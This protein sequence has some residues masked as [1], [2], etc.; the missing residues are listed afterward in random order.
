MKYK[1]IEEEIKELSE[2]RELLKLYI[3][4]SGDFP[5]Q[6]KIINAIQKK[7]VEIQKLRMGLPKEERENG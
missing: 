2:E 3:R 7:D 5:T 1:K 4:I 6:K